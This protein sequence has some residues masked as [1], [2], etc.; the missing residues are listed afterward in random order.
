MIQ[1]IFFDFNGVIIDDERIHLKAYR[2]VLQGE[3]V[4]LTDEDYFASLGM[5]DVAFV[6][7]AYGRAERLLTD[8]VM[9]ALIKREH[10][11]HREFITNDLPV[12]AGTVNFIKE[13]ARQFELGIVSMAE[14]GE[15]DYV[16]GLAGLQDSFSV[17]V[18]ADPGL[19]HKP[20][21]DCYQRALAILNEVRRT[22]RKLPLLP[23][24]CVAI[25]DAPPGI[26]AARSANMHTIGVT[27][28]VAEKP[29]RDAQADIVTPNLSDWCTEAVHRLFD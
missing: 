17:I 6:S 25:E 22:A 12:A 19:K 26:E 10:E 13:A 27:N 21:P 18:S 4:P 3:N 29:L 8:D 1:A 14:R 16:L 11:L 28:T 7:A 2:E 9:H 5:D 20:A 15:I 23:K 24:E